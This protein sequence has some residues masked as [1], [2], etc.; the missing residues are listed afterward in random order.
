MSA[1]N[2]VRSEM[3]AKFEQDLK[4]FKEKLITKMEREIAE[5]VKTSV[6]TALAGINAKI[7]FSF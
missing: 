3:Q 6:K 7:N 4:D 1:I 5:T 2:V